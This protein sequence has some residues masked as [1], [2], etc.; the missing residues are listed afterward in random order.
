VWY[1]LQAVE[2]ALLE[3]SIVNTGC[4]L[5]EGDEGS[6]KYLVAYIVPKGKVSRKEVRAE[7]KKRLPF[8]MIP[9]KFIFIGRQVIQI[10]ECSIIWR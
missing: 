8:Y 7:L 9:S 6:D 10:C 3:L 4:V 5:V 2:A 1:S